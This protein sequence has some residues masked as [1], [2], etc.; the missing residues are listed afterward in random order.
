[1]GSST[2][3][4]KVRLLPQYDAGGEPEPQ[5]A[6]A[7]RN[8]CGREGSPAGAGGGPRLR[9]E[10]GGERRRLTRQR[11]GRTYRYGVA[12][13]GR[14]RQLITDPLP[15]GPASSAVRG[16]GRADGVALEGS[17][18]RRASRCLPNLPSG[19]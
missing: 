17:A 9:F 18:R 3:G 10:P 14:G 8:N 15:N 11:S 19:P 5:A 13:A 1:M 7:R 2:K 6:P 12:G 16:D 4:V